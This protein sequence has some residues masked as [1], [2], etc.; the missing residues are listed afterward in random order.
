MGRTTGGGFFI[1]NR[2]ERRMRV[3]TGFYSSTSTSESG[4]EQ[5]IRIFP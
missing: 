2:D 3:G 1:L 5:Q 4:V